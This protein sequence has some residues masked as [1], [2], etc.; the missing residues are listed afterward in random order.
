MNFA[1]LRYSAELGKL[2]NNRP[3]CVSLTVK[4]AM[5]YREE[6]NNMCNQPFF[7]QTDHYELLLN[8]RL[9]RADLAELAI[10][11]W[12]REDAIFNEAEGIPLG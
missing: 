9:L 11:Q 2:R 3:S 10:R 7:D 8:S 4:R 6:M 1:L 12:L 5:G